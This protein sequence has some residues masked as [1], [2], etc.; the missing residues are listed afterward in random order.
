V[1][2]VLRAQIFACSMPRHGPLRIA[3]TTAS[4][5]KRPEKPRGDLLVGDA[6]PRNGALRRGC[7]LRRR[8]R[9]RSRGSL[10]RRTCRRR[11]GRRLSCARRRRSCRRSLLFHQFTPESAVC[12]ALVC[13]QNRQRKREREENAGQPCRK[14]HQHIGGLRS[15]NIFRD[16]PAKCCAQTFALWPLHQDHEY[17]EQGHENKKDEEQVDQETHRDGEYRQ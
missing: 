15:E 2:V 9:G 17:H 16:R 10:N 6:C 8:R 1:C 13:I 14:L 7:W 5:G 4:T 3:D 12:C 11:N